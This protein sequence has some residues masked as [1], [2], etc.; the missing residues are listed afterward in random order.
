MAAGQ[1][2][3]AGRVDLHCHSNAS[4]GR[5]TPSEVVA[6]ALAAGLTGLALTDHDTVDGLPEF[7]EAADRLGL[8]AIGGVEISLQHT[9]AM[10]LLGLDVMDGLNIPASLES[11]KKF[12]LERNIKMHSRLEEMGYHLSWDQLLQKAQGGQMGRPHFAALLVENGYFETIG[13]VFDQLLAK[14]KLGYMDKQRL[15]PE[16]GLDMLHRAGWISVLAHPVSLALEDGQ[17]ESCLNALVSQGLAGLEVYHPSHSPEQ[18]AFFRTLAHRFNLVETAGSDFHGSNRPSVGQDWVK[19]N[20]PLVGWEMI[21]AL[22][23][24]LNQRV[25]ATD[26]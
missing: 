12:R 19:N 18:I 16:E 22:R 4:D 26:S 20:S 14:G 24:K 15:S 13:E 17:W 10:H 2:A 25:G 7:F 21:D 6:G 9:G 23:N 8:K 11:L 3:S 5:L 1:D